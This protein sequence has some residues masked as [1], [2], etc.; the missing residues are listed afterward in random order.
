MSEYQFYEFRS[1][2][3]ALSDADQ[4]YARSLS[5]RAIVSSTTAQFNYSYSAFRGDPVK[6]LDRCFD[7]MLYVANFGTRRLMIRFPKNLVSL[8]A[9]KPYCDDHSITVASTPKSIILDIN[10]NSEDY[11]TWIEG[12]EHWLSG[13]VDLRE[14][15]LKGDFRLLYLA[16]L[17][18][19]FVEDGGEDPED[20]PE[21]P[22]PPN[23]KKLS[24]ALKRFAELFLVDADLIA[25]ATEVSPTLKEAE[26]PIEEWIAAMSEAER[27]RYLLKAIQGDAHVGAELMQHLRKVNDSKPM[28]AYVATERTLAN[29]IEHAQEQKKQHIQ[30]E[31]AKAAQAR[32]KQLEAIAPHVD[33][34]WE[35][36]HQLIALKQANP[37]DEAVNLLKDIRDLAELKGTQGKFQEKIVQLKRDY[38]NRPGLL[39]RL[40]K[41]RI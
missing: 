15:L 22:V 10:L 38:S 23:L 33:S 18:S 21:P 11:Y 41:A 4:A 5:S 12:E 17:R 9:F 26:E 40:Q 19:G 28:N 29:L 7:L 14:E 36:I 35:K 39:T 32:R 20:M 8:A 25:A 16:W 27:N 3:K 6:L 31:Q 24:P 13:L 30:K 37:Y 1:L 34:L 2:D